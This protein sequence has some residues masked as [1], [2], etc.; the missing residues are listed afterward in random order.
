MVL[1]H[2]SFVP[3]QPEVFGLTRDEG[4]MTK[5]PQQKNV[6]APREGVDVMDQVDTLCVICT[7]L[8]LVLGLLFGYGVA[9]L[10]DRFR[11]NNIRTQALEITVNAK[12]QADNLIKDAEL[13]SKEE[14]FKQREVL[15]REAELKRA[16]LREQERRLE[17]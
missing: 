1:C 8:A 3:D 6:R 4:P 5:D 16:E 9:R 7:C 10:T 17:K 15:D 12:T 2:W 11:L 14:L 13:R